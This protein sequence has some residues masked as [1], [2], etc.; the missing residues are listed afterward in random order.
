MSETK[1]C[2]CGTKDFSDLVANLC[3]VAMVTDPR[4][5][6]GCFYNVL[7]Y[8]SHQIYSVFC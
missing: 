5:Y 1:D 6:N 7:G 8:F 4:S 2:V 3:T